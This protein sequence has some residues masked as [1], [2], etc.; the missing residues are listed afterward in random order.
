MTALCLL[1]E[2]DLSRWWDDHGTLTVAAFAPIAAAFGSWLGTR[3][4]RKTQREA[5]RRDTRLPTYQAFTRS[6]EE[7]RYKGWRYR[8]DKIGGSGEEPPDPPPTDEQLDELI[9]QARCHLADV[10]LVG[11]EKVEEVARSL[12]DTAAR[13]RW[14]QAT[15]SDVDEASVPFRNEAK[16]AL[17]LP[18]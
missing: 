5:W 12:F 13:L 14:L 8:W 17:D 18:G 10:E 1:A 9:R 4:T 15:P 6:I 3:G 7:L 2:I 11:P 16:A